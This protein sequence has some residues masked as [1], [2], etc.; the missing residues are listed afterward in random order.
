MMPKFLQMV[1]SALALAQCEVVWYFQHVGI[2]SSKSTRGRT[3]DIVSDFVHFVL[4][5]LIFVSF[6]SNFVIKTFRM[7]LT[8]P[9]V[10]Y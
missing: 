8:P 6:L 5:N 9:L 7:Q 1:F 2:A 3:V 4:E 10:S